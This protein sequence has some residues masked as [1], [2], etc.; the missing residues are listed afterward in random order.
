LRKLSPYSF[1]TPTRENRAQIW[2]HC[3]RSVKKWHE[4]S[5]KRR[6]IDD[7]GGNWDVAVNREKDERDSLK[8][9]IER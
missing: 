5:T 2:S 3:R 4:N 9:A 8:L 6:K 7:G 1:R